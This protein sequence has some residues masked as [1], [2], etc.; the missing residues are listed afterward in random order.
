MV[1]YTSFKISGI[2]FKM[3]FKVIY[4]RIFIRWNRTSLVVIR[5]ANEK[6]H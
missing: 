6:N 3:E 2:T 4:N 1:Q 5:F